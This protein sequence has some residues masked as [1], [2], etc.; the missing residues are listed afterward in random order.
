LFTVEDIMDKSLIET[1]ARGGEK[2]RSAIE[3]LAPAQ[4]AA[5]PI[6]GKWSVQQVVMHLH[7]SDLIGMDRMKRIIAMNKP[8]LVDYDESAF[9]RSLHYDKQSTA[10]A[11]TILDLSFKNFARVLRELPDET[12]AR[13]GVHTERGLLKL[14]DFLE[15]MVHHL[16]HHLKFIDEKRNAL[17]K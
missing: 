5:I 15:H 7:D 8:L 13:Q 16:D 10:D 6:P 12:F 14:G 4:L 2:L 3:G 17:G 1:Y 9:A 11:V